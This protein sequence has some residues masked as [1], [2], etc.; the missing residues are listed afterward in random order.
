MALVKIVSILLIFLAYET[1]KGDDGNLIIE[2]IKG[3]DECN[4]RTRTGDWITWHY[5]GKLT[6]GFVFDTSIGKKPYGAKLGGHRIIDGVDQGMYGMCVG[7]I[8]KLT[9]PSRLGYGS[10]GSGNIP[11][12]ATLIFVNEL[13]SVEKADF[14]SML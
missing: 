8:R 7:D 3:A 6:D 1:V 12:N 14:R 11:G 9:M 10:R 5:T 4:Y 2:V 13:V